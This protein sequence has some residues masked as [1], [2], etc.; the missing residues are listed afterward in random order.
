VLFLR[1]R[2]L[3]PREPLDFPVAVEA[4][5]LQEGQVVTGDVAPQAGP[6]VERSR[7]TDGH[8]LGG[9]LRHPPHQVDHPPD[10][11]VAFR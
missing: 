10:I 1:C 4:E 6:L 9:P 5:L 2:G 7:Q 11:E 8:G 3:D